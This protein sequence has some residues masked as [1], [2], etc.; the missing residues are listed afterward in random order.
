MC[1][2]GRNIKIKVGNHSVSYT[3][4]GSLNAMAVIFIHGF[5]LNKSMWNSQLETLSTSYRVIA[6]DIRGHGDSDSGNE[7]FSIELFVKDLI[8]IMNALS[9]KKAV[10]CGFSMGGYIALNAVEN[11]PEYFNALLLCDTHCIAD[12]LEAREKRMKSIGNIRENGV[13]KYADESLINLITPKT[14]DKNKKLVAQLKEMMINTSR[15]S[16]VKTLLA[17]SKRKETCSKL[18]GINIPVQILVGEHDMITPPEAAQ[19]L[20][21]KIK[22]AQLSTIKHAAHISNMENPE[23]FNELLKAFV[24]SVNQ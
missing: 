22:G 9:I 15:Q 6:Y 11:H 16:L 1:N 12:N 19:Y 18:P 20:H 23:Q 7:D 2:Q 10:L 24:D 14:F 21:N 13:E 5:P 8:G 17:L 4:E 3:D